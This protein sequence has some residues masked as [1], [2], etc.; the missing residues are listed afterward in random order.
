MLVSVVDLL[1]VFGRLFVLFELI[2][3]LIVQFGRGTHGDL[4][5]VR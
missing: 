5:S 3:L 2:L 1:Y 4:V